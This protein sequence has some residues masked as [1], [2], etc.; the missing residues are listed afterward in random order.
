MTNEPRAMSQF[1]Y[2]DKR[3][4]LYEEMLV[5]HISY[6]FPGF[7]GQL[8]NSQLSPATISTLRLQNFRNLSPV[9]A[10][11]EKTSPKGEVDLNSSLDSLATLLNVSHPQLFVIDFSVIAISLHPQ[12]F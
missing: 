7:N 4:I 11:I 1:S 8:D 2:D 3:K 5:H 9:I 6:I 12:V 10:A